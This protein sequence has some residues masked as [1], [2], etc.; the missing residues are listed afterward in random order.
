M[1]YYGAETEYPSRSNPL[2][3]LTTPH[4]PGSIIAIG[5]EADESTLTYVVGSVADGGRLHVVTLASGVPDESYEHNNGPL[6]D[7]GVNS[8]H[9]KTS[10]D[11]T[12]TLSRLDNRSTL[13]LGGGNQRVLIDQIG[14]YGGDQLRQAH[15]RGITIAGTSAGAMVVGDVAVIEESGKRSVINGLGLI[16]G[17]AID[18][19][20]SERERQARL[21]WLTRQRGVL[22]I[23][24]DEGTGFITHDSQEIEVIGKGGVHII[25]V[26]GEVDL[27]RGDRFNL[28]TRQVVDR[29]H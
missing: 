10:L 7:L 18:S 2:E 29:A 4:S 16:H 22:G 17:I 12:N 3:G 13:F 26:G 14:K 5:G 21:R 25:H 11:L 1:A 6:V 27:E 19:H 24:I 20:Y 28:G 23:G 8:V 15:Q 9:I